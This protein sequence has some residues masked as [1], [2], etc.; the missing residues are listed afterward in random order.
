MLSV[1][2]SVWSVWDCIW[3]L[4]KRPE[5]TWIW[6]GKWWLF[7]HME[8]VHSSLQGYMEAV[9]ANSL[10]LLL[11]FWSAGLG[12]WPL[13][14]NLLSSCT[15]APAITSVF[16]TMKKKNRERQK[17]HAS[18]SWPLPSPTHLLT[19]NG[20]SYLWG[21][22]GPCSAGHVVNPPKHRVD[23]KEGKGRCWVW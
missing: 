19:S 13:S 12:M 17:D 22:I 18:L 3:L 11:S 14:S 21:R 8:V 6:I 23:S 5:N 2:C 10:R 4:L 1:R 16:W 15:V 9:S 7:S 20:H